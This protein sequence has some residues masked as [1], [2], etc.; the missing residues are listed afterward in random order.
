MFYYISKT[1]GSGLKTMPFRLA[2][3]HLDSISTLPFMT[4]LAL[5][6]SHSTSFQTSV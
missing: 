1:V 6:V 3:T 2:A 5:A 4:V